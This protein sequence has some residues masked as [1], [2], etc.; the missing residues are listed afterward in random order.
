M[1][2]SALTLAV[3]ISVST[4]NQV[5]DREMCEQQKHANK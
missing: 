5:F 1:T 3:R 2:R 4:R